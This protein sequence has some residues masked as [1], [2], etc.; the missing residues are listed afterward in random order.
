MKTEL[1]EGEMDYCFNLSELTAKKDMVAFI[2]NV[3]KI[4]SGSDRVIVT[5][6]AECHK[7][8]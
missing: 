2:Q 7:G 3:R 6:N 1:R 8:R 4:A 5:E